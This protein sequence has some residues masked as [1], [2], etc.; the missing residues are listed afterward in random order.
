VPDP[1]RLLRFGLV[2]GVSTL[3]YAVV[4]WVLTYPVALPA[5]VASIIAYC[6]GAVFSYTAH[7]NVTFRSDRPVA[8]E[9]SRFA[10]VSFAGWIVAIISPLILTTLLGL[11]AVVAIVF[12]SVAVPILSFIGLERFVFRPTD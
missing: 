4:A 1:W 12:A 9:A 5:V 7:R 11:P 8:E 3:I 10:G 2:G 6:L